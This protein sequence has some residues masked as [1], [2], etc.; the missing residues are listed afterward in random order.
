MFT[1]AKSLAN[2]PECL[3]F[4]DLRHN[5]GS[6]LLSEG[7]PITT[8]SRILGHANVSITLSV[9]AHQLPED[10]DTVAEVMSSIYRVG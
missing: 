1:G 3:R 6:L 8:V 4:H 9:Y 5:C 7:V 2:V 10:L